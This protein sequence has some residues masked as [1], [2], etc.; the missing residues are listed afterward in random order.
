MNDDD[1]DY[2]REEASYLLFFIKQE[3]EILLVV[4]VGNIK[5]CDLYI[6]PIQSNPS[7]ISATSAFF[8]FYFVSLLA[9][10][11]VFLMDYAMSLIQI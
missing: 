11:L 7:L 5:C 2:D 1:D 4:V 9:V 8:S 10:L 3:E 6:N